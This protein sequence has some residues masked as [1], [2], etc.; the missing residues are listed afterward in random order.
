MRH[1]A[2]NP[3][4]WVYFAQEIGSRAIKIGQ[5]TW[6][7]ARIISLS[8]ANA[9]PVVLLGTLDYAWGLDLGIYK[10][11]SKHRLKGEWFS[12]DVED[13]VRRVI[14]RDGIPQ[15]AGLLLG[16]KFGDIITL[17]EFARAIKLTPGDTL[18][19]IN[20][21]IDVW[22]AALAKDDCSS[23]NRGAAQAVLDK[24]YW[25]RYGEPPSC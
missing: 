10:K 2:I 21:D 14:T 20:R 22:G 4:K 5:S 1:R 12:R 24:H 16:S 8:N 17:K 19:W 9:Y 13:F 11:L 3:K 6:P 23:L 7:W 25:A 18:A 15:L